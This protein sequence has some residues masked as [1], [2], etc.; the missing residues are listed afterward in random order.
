MVQGLHLNGMKRYT[1]K[2]RAFGLDSRVNG[3]PVVEPGSPQVGGCESMTEAE[4][5]APPA[6]SSLLPAA[7]AA[8][9]LVASSRAPVDGSGHFGEGASIHVGESLM[10]NPLH[11]EVICS[12][13]W[14]K[15]PFVS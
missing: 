14:V 3:V 2:S 8:A 13:N 15:A 10:I 7:P 1:E 5:D 9:L 6:P 12:P 4:P 11:P